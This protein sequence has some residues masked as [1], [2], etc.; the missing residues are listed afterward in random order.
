MRTQPS[1]ARKLTPT[2]RGD[3]TDDVRQDDEM[4][5]DLLRIVVNLVGSVI[6]HKQL[7]SRA[8]PPLLQHLTSRI[9]QGGTLPVHDSKT[10]EACVFSST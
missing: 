7:A 10:P 6:L 3:G 5:A 8:R 2:R 1:F 4:D 9:V